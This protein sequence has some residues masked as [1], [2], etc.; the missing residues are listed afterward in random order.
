MT[1]S[2][3]HAPAI[4][5]LCWLLCP[6]VGV[7]GRAVGETKPLR[8]AH[9]DRAAVRGPRVEQGPRALPAISNVD[10]AV[11]GGGV[12]GVTAALEAAGQGLSVVLVEPRNYFGC[13]LTATELPTTVP[14][15][16][17]AGFARADR[18]CRR[19]SDQEAY[20]REHV[21]SGKLKASLRDLVT[22]EARIKP[23]L[24]SWPCGVVLEGNVVRGVVMANRSGRQVVLAKAVIDA[25]P[26]GR[27]AA[28][29][30]ATFAR[31]WRGEKTIERTVT[32]SDHNPLKTGVL[33]VPEDLGLVGN[34][35]R[36]LGD[37]T[38]VVQF[39]LPASIGDDVA[40]DLSTAQA[41]SLERGIS[42]LEYFESTPEAFR[43][44]R[45]D[46][47]RPLRDRYP[48]YRFGPEVF[49]REGP[50]VV[51][52]KPLA[53]GSFDLAA[54]AEPDSCRPE[55]IEGIVI[56]G[57]TVSA[58]AE[59]AG[60]QALACS[61]EQSGRVAAEIAQRA[62][63]VAIEPPA[64][65]APSVTSAARRVAEILTGPDPNVPYPCIRQQAVE[66]P[67]VE[68]ADVLVVGGG[69]SGAP[70]AIAAARKGA[71]VVLAELLPNLGGTGSN[72]VNG[73]YWGVT[74]RSK[75][76]E[77]INVKT[78][79]WLRVR[80][81]YR[82]NGEE[83]KVALQELA[84]AAG[85]KLYYQ[86]L[87]AG[88]VMEGNT[89]A[90]LVV[91]NAAGRQVI[92]AKMVIDA[93]GHGDVAASAGATFGKG[94]TSDGFMH[95]VDR[96]GL[97]D[98]TNVEDMSAFLMKR[99]TSSI[100]LNVRE[101]R[102]ITGDYVLTFDDSI[103]GRN[104]ADLVCRWRSNYD[105][106]F[107]SSANMSDLAQDWVV[108]LGLWRRPILANVPYRCL[109]PKGIDNLLVVGKSF[110]V[111]HDTGI[112]A[113]MQRDLQHLGEA[114][115]VAAALAARDGT[116]ARE[117]PIE[118]LQ[119]EL[120]RIGVLRSEDLAAI[121]APKAP[122]DPAAAAAKLGTADSLDAM[123]ELYLAGD[124]SV[125]ALRPLLESDANDVRADAALLLGMHGDG[126]AI[127]ELLRCLEQRNARTHRFTLVDCSSRPSVPMW[128]AS[129][130]L[131]GR[132]REKAAVPLL[133]D[134]LN[135]PDRCPPDLASFAIT[136]LE[137]IGDPVAVDVIK[138]Y[139]KT[140][141]S[142]PVENENASFETM[143]GVRTNAARALARLGDTSG[144][145]ELIRLLDAE[146]ALARDYA[147]R[148]LE[149][150]TDQH[151]GK[152]RRRWQAW[153]DEHGRRR[154]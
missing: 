133:V 13:E 60:L 35:V 129:V 76:S 22:D 135:D 132:F 14:H 104:F 66:L 34:Q 128:Y 4:W 78:H 16:P 107:P 26:D 77:E 89:I 108:L 1:S 126:S 115:G 3:R 15:Q 82:F 38:Q 11:A 105:T 71:K 100:A 97:R 69:T 48:R 62:P 73:Y 147:Q 85:V 59:M 41:A 151:F 92:L 137:R 46:P 95:E 36:V 103:H 27:L 102:R 138:P 2:W 10:V 141:E 21:S 57:R 122:F 101:S 144:A 9:V 37:R 32:L 130:I 148:L 117:V 52:R 55:G 45:I 98:P 123:V 86:T 61:G 119:Q 145:A 63:A 96:N 99:P 64:A 39:A 43:N 56:A 106:H 120:V 109:L 79:T 23:Y 114:A 81:K 42:L 68:Q 5:L 136:A 150:I 44:G 139:L 25:T 53:D 24:F 67:V 29:A 33:D 94:R 51:C 6:L 58:A 93:T 30:G 140:G 118:K 12:A 91:E 124:V 72:R 146:Q 54:L 134:V 50:V 142:A 70:A 131:L 116:T 83:K 88:V 7:E 112:G 153:W 75:L 18:L 17:A 74:W 49:V 28:A 31:T 47:E 110:S 19:W 154:N 143:W 90:G 84:R 65:A 111:D 125:P 121:D 127:P 149:E 87:G 80:E 40:G 20:R 152:D 8:I 113:R